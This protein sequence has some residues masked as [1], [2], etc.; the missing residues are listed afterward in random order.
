MGL[1]QK[2]KDGKEER[3]KGEYTPEGTSPIHCS[4]K[5]CLE[6]ESN[7]HLLIGIHATVDDLIKC[8][9]LLFGNDSILRMK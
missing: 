5:N 1:H 4:D 6:K 3:K 7:I 8:R 9:T 2:Q